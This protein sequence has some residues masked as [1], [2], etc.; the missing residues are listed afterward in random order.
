MAEKYVCLVCKNEVDIIITYE[1]IPIKKWIFCHKCNV[2][3]KHVRI[4]AV[5]RK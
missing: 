5:S 2:E 3:R 4:G 1:P